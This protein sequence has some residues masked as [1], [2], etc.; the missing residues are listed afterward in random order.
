MVETPETPNTVCV[1]T[2]SEDTVSEDRVSEDT[3]LE[4]T[5]IRGYCIKRT[6]LGPTGTGD[7]LHPGGVLRGVN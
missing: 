7:L 5:L 6:Q 2:V 1:S 4:S 3:V